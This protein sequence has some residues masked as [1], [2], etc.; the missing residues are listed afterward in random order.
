[1]FVIPYGK[2]CMFTKNV[3]D[4]GES[5]LIEVSHK[6]RNKLTPE[7]LVFLFR[8]N[9]FKKDPSAKGRSRSLFSVDSNKVLYVRNTWPTY[10]QKRLV[11]PT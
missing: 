4:D 7:S 6:T 10:W 9:A 3:I 5:D 11:V 1:M 8:F 2:L